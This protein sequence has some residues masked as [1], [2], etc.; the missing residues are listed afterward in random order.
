MTDWKKAHDNLEFGL[1]WNDSQDDTSFRISPVLYRWDRYNT[2]NSAGRFDEAL[3]PD[4]SGDG[5][6][7]GLGFGSGSGTRRIDSFATRT[8]AKTHEPQDVRLE[9]SCNASTGTWVYGVGFVTTG[10]FYTNWHITVPALASYGVTYNANGGTGAPSAQTKWHGE[11]LTLSSTKPTRA[12]YTFQGW[13]T[14][15][16]GGVKYA[17]GA[18]FESNAA[19]TLYAVWKVV[20]PSAP[21]NCVNTRDS[22]TKNTVSWKL[23]ANAAATYANVEVYRSVDGGAWSKAAT[24]AKSATSWADAT[25]SANHSYAYRV[26]AVNATGAS[27]WATSGTTYNTPA[28][29]TKIAPSRT[30][31]TS[32]RVDVENP[33]KTAT[34]LELQRSA[35]GSAWSNPITFSG[36]VTTLVDE[37]GGGTW[38]YRARN[39][40]GTL[41]SAWSPASA[42]VVTMCAPAAPTLVEPA[43]GQVVEHSTPEVAFAWR[44]NPLDGSAQTAAEVRYSTDGGK[45]WQTVEATTEQSATIANAFEVN[46]DVT[47]SVRTKGAHADFGPWSGNGVFSVKQAPSVA[48]AKPADGFV[49][50]NTPVSVELQYSDASG[51]YAGGVLTI[52]RGGVIERTF[53]MPEKTLRITVGEWLPQDG[54]AYTF[55]ASVRSTSTLTASATREVTVDFVLPQAADLLIEPDPETGRVQIVCNLADAEGRVPAVSITLRRVSKDGGVLLGSALPEGAGVTD[56]YAPLNSDY[57]YEA[58]TIADSGA[59]CTVS[60]PARADTEW[61]F[62]YFGGDLARG[63][64]NPTHSFSLV[65]SVEYVRYAGR[66]RPVAYM[67][68]YDDESHS[69]SFV[70]QTMEEADAFKRMMAACEPVVAKLPSGEVFRAVPK[71]SATE[72]LGTRCLYG[73]V[74]VDLTVIDGDAL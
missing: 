61:A 29:P 9:L 53:D 7:G 11:V 3:S 65:P 24:V 73:D 2:D 63:R 37:P 28:A 17:A 69:V 72:N 43:R 40:R 49:I 1:D 42:P 22:D 41:A 52:E 64:W 19:T 34:A 62:M 6:W 32:V 26:R 68:D 66:K 20:A 30:G 31:E 46:A 12:G 15:S 67:E 56:A 27:G 33:A 8:Y 21:A 23:G 71:V 13:S 4:P 48:F 47:W 57:A 51:G 10:E 38:V 35:D 16:T 55:R 36:T 70:L 59:A 5:W 44:H 74:S 39:T 54:A 25:C 50:E 58:T 18:R 60:F 45:T 14:S